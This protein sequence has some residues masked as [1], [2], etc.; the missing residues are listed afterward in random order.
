MMNDERG[1]VVWLA[2][3]PCSRFLDD[4]SAIEL[5][6]LPAEDIKPIFIAS[7]YVLSKGSRNVK[8]LCV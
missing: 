4:G 8:C 5:G 2:M 3:C 6:A 7:W 1:P